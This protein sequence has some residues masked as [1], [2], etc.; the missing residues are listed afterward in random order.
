MSC[1]NY[2]NANGCRDRHIILPEDKNAAPVI[3]PSPKSKFVPHAKSATFYNCANFDCAN[4][5]PLSFRKTDTNDSGENNSM[6]A[7]RHVFGDRFVGNRPTTAT[8]QI[9]GGAGQME[10]VSANETE[11]LPQALADILQLR[12]ISPKEGI[13][14]LTAEPIKIDGDFK[15]FSSNGKKN[16][17]SPG[18]GP[19]STSIIRQE[20]A[21]RHQHPLATNVV[22]ADEHRGEGDRTTAHGGS[23]IKN[24]KLKLIL[25]LPKNIILHWAL[26]KLTGEEGEELEAL[27]KHKP[28]IVANRV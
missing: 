22:T 28:Q 17:K 23:P 24:E 7:P 16:S 8:A 27:L 10:T 14:I 5:S 15:K 21:I 18:I 1:V 12:M 6:G 20:E 4:F 2:Y 25:S 3:V 13:K 11:K 26:I 9:A 19:R